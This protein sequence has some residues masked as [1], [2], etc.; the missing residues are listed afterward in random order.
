MKWALVDIVMDLRVLRNPEH[1]CSYNAV[2]SL[3]A[4]D[5]G[6]TTGLDLFCASLVFLSSDFIASFNLVEWVPSVFFFFLHLRQQVIQKSSFS[7]ASLCLLAYICQVSSRCVLH[8]KI[9]HDCTVRQNKFVKNS[10]SAVSQAQ[11]WQRPLQW[12]NVF[13]ESLSNDVTNVCTFL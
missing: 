5:F 11:C 12:C 7:V 8:N 2:C 3:L 1:K 10:L 4:F 6:I 13:H 9:S